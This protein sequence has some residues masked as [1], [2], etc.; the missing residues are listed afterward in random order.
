[1]LRINAQITKIAK[2]MSNISRTILHHKSE[3]SDK[4][5]I[6]DVNRITGEYPYVVSATWGKRQAPNLSCMVKGTFRNEYQAKALATSLIADK[7]K[8]KAGYEVA[9]PGLEI[10]GLQALKH[11]NASILHASNKE[12]V[13]PNIVMN[14]LPSGPVRKIKI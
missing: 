12:P 6:I 1:M 11:A 14:V 13:N 10:T 3:N 4:V 7:R 2:R 9:L 8:S 5:Y